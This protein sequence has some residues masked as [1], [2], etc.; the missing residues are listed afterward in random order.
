MYFGK[1]IN[2]NKDV[3]H[4]QTSNRVLVAGGTQGIGAGIALRFA[5]AGATVWVVGRSEE[6]GVEIVKKLHQASLEAA[7]RRKIE[8]EDSDVDHAFFQ[9]DLSDVEEIKRVAEDVR[10]RSGKEGIDWLFE[11]Q[12][13]PP[14]GNAPNTPKGID[15]H[16]AVQCLSR[17][18]LA[19]SLLESGTIKRAVCIVA[20]PGGGSSTP[21]SLDDLELKEAKKTWSM[22]GP[23]K[24]PVS[25]QRDSSVIDAFTQH[26]AEQ[27]PNL[28]ISHLFPGIVGTKSA[29]NSG[30]PFPIPQ[31]ASL[32]SYVL[33]S[34]EQYAEVPFYLH[35][36]AEGGRYLRG[37]EVNLF[38][39]TLKRYD[40]SKNV[41]TKEARQG[42]VDKLKSYGL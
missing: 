33:P 41:A 15:S 2:S 7:R 9:A 23:L 8:Q 18:G 16:F 12:G 14:T 27:Y 40:I 36:H 5:L 26:W 42:V 37:G 4:L 30:F 22:F 34:A 21:L 19:N 29:A 1:F 10:K 24:I 35:T 28:T 31:V 39:P 13:G 25:G 6:R 38:G 20:A 17:F 3:D 11:T 32:A